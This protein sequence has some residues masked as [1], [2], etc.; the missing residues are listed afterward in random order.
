MIRN[1]H[2]LRWCS[3]ESTAEGGVSVR[4]N[5]KLSGYVVAFLVGIC[6]VLLQSY[7]TFHSSSLALLGD[8][9]HALVDTTLVYGIAILASIKKGRGTSKKDVIH[10]DNRWGLFIQ[11]ALIVIGATLIIFGAGRLAIDTTP[12][13]VGPV[14]L[15]TSSI[16]LGLNLCVL[17]ILQKLRIDHG[18]AHE[19]THD[20]VHEGAF[21][22]ALGDTAVSVAVVCTGIA[23]TFFSWN[24]SWIDSAVTLCVGF[25]FISRATQEKKKI[26]N[27]SH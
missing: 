16:G 25:F 4:C 24:I 19:N 27:H 3:L 7:G 15:A 1:G 8:T 12:D 14:M 9:F 5:C 11:N 17:H 20:H 21:T 6:V 13:I 10:I 18:H 2:W 23:I 22:H 26:N